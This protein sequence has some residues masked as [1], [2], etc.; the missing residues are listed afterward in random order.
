MKVATFGSCLSRNTAN[1]LVAD[2][3]FEIMSCV[4]HVMSE[5]FVKYYVEKTHELPDLDWLESMFVA[6]D[7]PKSVHYANGMLR[8]Q[9]PEQMGL[10]EFSEQDIPSK[11]RFLD[12]IE[13]HEV[14][15][16]L[17]DNFIDMS[18][19]PMFYTL[20]PK[21]SESPIQF[22]YHFY[23]NSEE[24]LKKFRF[25]GYVSPR[26]SAKNYLKIMEWLKKKQPKAKIA[27]LSF[28]GCTSD[29]NPE[30]QQ[31][32][33]DFYRELSTIAPK[34]F[35]VL[36]PLDVPKV[37]QIEGDWSHVHNSVYRGLAGKLFVDFIIQP[38]NEASSSKGWRGLPWR[39]GAYKAQNP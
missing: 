4:F 38:S 25:G 8:N 15:L 32:A 1:Y 23:K 31:R 36:P 5:Q 26:D 35:L 6:N 3:E 2:F 12:L 13:N 14:D 16:I 24:L 28:F 39:S 21:L 33:L 34:E 9:Y 18:S 29:G 22:V 37:L 30:R 7:D 10:W 11:I 20:D 19:W 27:F 17:L